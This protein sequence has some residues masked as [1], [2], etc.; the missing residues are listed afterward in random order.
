MTSDFQNWQGLLTQQSGGGFGT[1]ALATDP[2]TQT[3]RSNISNGIS[4]EF[5]TS[6]PIQYEEFF[7]KF[8][9]LAAR[10]QTKTSTN[11]EYYI[12]TPD[13]FALYDLYLCMK[14]ELRLK[15]TT[16]SPPLTSA[17]P[18]QCIDDNFIDNFFENNTFR[19]ASG[20]EN[21]SKIIPIDMLMKAKR[22]THLDAPAYDQEQF[23]K[24]GDTSNFGPNANGSF[25]PAVGEPVVFDIAIP[26]WMLDGTGLFGLFKQFPPNLIMTIILSLQTNLNNI[27]RPFTNQYLFDYNQYCDLVI[28][29]EYLR[30]RTTT[31]HPDVQ[32]SDSQALTAIKE[33]LVRGAQNSGQNINLSDITDGA[34]LSN[35]LKTMN[36]N[37]LNDGQLPSLLSTPI[38]MYPTN[39]FT[40][41]SL[42]LGIPPTY[43]SLF[44]VTRDDKLVLQQQT[45]CK[46]ILFAIRM[47]IRKPNIQNVTDTKLP[48]AYFRS[49]FPSE[50]NNV[51]I[52]GDPVDGPYS[53]IEPL[54]AGQPLISCNSKLDSRRQQQDNNSLQPVQYISTKQAVGRENTTLYKNQKLL[55]FLMGLATNK[56]GSFQYEVTVQNG[57][58]NLEFSYVPARCTR[59]DVILYDRQALTIDADDK[60]TNG[61]NDP[62]FPH[63]INTITLI[64]CK[65]YTQQ[66]NVDLSGYTAFLRTTQ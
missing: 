17:N 5:V 59:P 14:V 35:T 16:P 11:L 45:I 4:S 9:V 46:S 55:P 49:I 28:V 6:E 61:T 43:A 47:T 42:S 23:Y 39:E 19:I 36:P 51:P 24:Y 57:I 26:L 15:A 33:L 50:V 31:L 8:E 30:I 44:D 54:R 38:H 64:V 56:S 48:L 12:K 1:S 40:I 22:L 20:Q 10:A 52:A 63:C 62:G 2:T 27:F 60:F 3:M 32:Q 41:S 25:T 13:P 18:M 65:I 53:G 37:L 58:L 29:E 7:T 66:V 21:R 34:A